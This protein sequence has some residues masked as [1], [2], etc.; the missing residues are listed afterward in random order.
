MPIDLKLIDGGVR[1]SIPDAGLVH[2]TSLEGVFDVR[3]SRA[4]AI[5]LARGLAGMIRNPED[6]P[7]VA[8]HAVIFHFDYVVDNENDTPEWT[9]GFTFDSPGEADAAVAAINAECALL[10]PDRDADENYAG[11]NRFP[12]LTHLASSFEH[13]EAGTPVRAVLDALR[14]EILGEEGIFDARCAAKVNHLHRLGLC[15][16]EEDSFD[17]DDGENQARLEQ[18][19]LIPFKRVQY[20]APREGLAGSILIPDVVLYAHDYSPHADAVER[21]ESVASAFATM[22]PTS[23]AAASTLNLTALPGWVDRDGNPLTES[24]FLDE[25]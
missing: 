25:D 22:R 14:L 1:V 16:G 7:D 11:R 5:D 8:P 2:S 15:D 6:W 4:Q 19:E 17:Y 13:F 24:P 21:S 18:P 9:T 23:L 12:E 10:F 3:L 20:S